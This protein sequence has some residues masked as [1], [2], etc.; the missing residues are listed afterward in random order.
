MES[1]W[2]EVTGA[3][4]K[5]TTAPL[6]TA[7]MVGLPVTFFF[8]DIWSELRRMCVFQAGG[9]RVC[10][11]DV[12]EE[13]TVP[14]EVMRKSGCT[15]RIGLCGLNQEGTLVLPT[16]WVDV[17]VIQPGAD[18]EA[19]PAMDPQLPIWRQNEELAKQAMAVAESV[20]KDA[21][22]GAF[23]G[24]AGPVGPQGPEGP[25]G[26]TGPAGEPG[27]QGPAGETGPQGPQGPTGA[28]GATGPTGARG[29]QG[30]TGKT[31]PAG[32]TPVKGVDY[33]TEEDKEEIR[34]YVDEAILG[35]AW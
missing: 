3:M 7:G 32:P 24:A 25:A 23:Q 16:V 4:A 15:L 12:Q 21:D 28:R 1:I 17:G 14:W 13:T 9:T 11:P 35:G 18:P 6:L 27:P 22:A 5:V 33:W 29:P 20:R 2:I 30:L 26:K 31:G 10:C 19:D 8:D 34:A